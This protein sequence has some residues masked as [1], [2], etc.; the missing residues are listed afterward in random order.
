[1]LSG[2]D[3]AR[4]GGDR[5]RQQD[6]EYPCG[7]PAAHG[8]IVRYGPEFSHR[9]PSRVSAG[10]EVADCCQNTANTMASC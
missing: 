9:L 2:L 5:A 4:A 6:G 3:A 1:L 7:R 8:L 10:A